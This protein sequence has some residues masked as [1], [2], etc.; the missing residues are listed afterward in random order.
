[1]SVQKLSYRLEGGPTTTTATSL[2]APA[3]HRAGV[4]VHTTIRQRPIP[5]GL[6]RKICQWEPERCVSRAE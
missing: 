5:I 1:V 6:A 3:F 2:C 4:S